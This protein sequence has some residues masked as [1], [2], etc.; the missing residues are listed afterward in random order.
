MIVGTKLADY[1]NV[2]IAHSSGD[3]HVAHVPCIT[4]HDHKNG[5]RILLNTRKLFFFLN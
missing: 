4:H 2:D 3:K 1:A 5:I